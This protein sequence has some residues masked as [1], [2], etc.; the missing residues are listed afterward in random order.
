MNCFKDRVL[1]KE[2][3]ENIDGVYFIIEG[4]VRHTKE[5]PYMDID[6]K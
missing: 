1:Y 4:M 3:D 6:L 2:G 5:D